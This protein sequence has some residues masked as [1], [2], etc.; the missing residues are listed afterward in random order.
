MKIVCETYPDGLVS[1]CW[2]PKA[3]KYVPTDV[4]DLLANFI[5]AEISDVY[6]GCDDKPEVLYAEVMRALVSARTELTEVIIALDAERAKIITKSQPK[7][8]TLDKKKK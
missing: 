4:G 1:A 6:K 3:T 5:A 8:K 2:D 7:P